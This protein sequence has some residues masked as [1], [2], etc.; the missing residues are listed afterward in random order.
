VPY[1]NL[2]NSNAAQVIRS[3]SRKHISRESA[4]NDFST[5]YK[6]ASMQEA[7]VLKDP[8]VHGGSGFGAATVQYLGIEPMLGSTS[9]E[10]TA[11]GIRKRVIQVGEDLSA[12]E[13]SAGGVSARSKRANKKKGEGASG[14]ALLSLKDVGPMRG[15]PEPTSR[16]KATVN[17]EGADRAVEGGP[18]GRRIATT[19]EVMMKHGLT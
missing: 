3:Y 7:S 17:A 1:N 14:G 15:Q 19:R 8:E 12:A 18:R 5:S 13:V 16:A 4:I 10:D 9:G 11:K 2:C 6:I